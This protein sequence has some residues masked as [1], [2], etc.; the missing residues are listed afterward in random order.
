VVAV[1]N[2]ENSA[3]AHERLIDCRH[4][5]SPFLIFLR[6]FRE[7]TLSASVQVNQLGH[8]HYAIAKTY[9]AIAK[10]DHATNV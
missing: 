4:F 1:E 3:A 2:A 6:N 10:A 9:L 5:V 8:F 7:I